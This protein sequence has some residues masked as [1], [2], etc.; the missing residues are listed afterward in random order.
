MNGIALIDCNS[1]YASC[2]QLFRPDLRDRAVVVLSNNDGCIIARNELAK[3][4]QIPMGVPFFQ[5]QRVLDQAGAAIFS[6]NYALYGDLSNRVMSLLEQTAPEIEVYSIDEAFADCSGL[7]LPKQIVLVQQMYQQVTQWVGLPIG[8]GLAPNKTLAKLANRLAKTDAHRP[9]MIGPGQAS[10]HEAQHRAQLLPQIPIHQVWGVGQRLAARLS[11]MG[12]KT[13]ADLAERDPTLIKRQFNRLLEGTLR[14]LRGER[15]FALNQ[16]PET[17]H[18][19]INSRSLK[20]STNDPTILKQAL[21][22]HAAKCGR[23]LRRQGLVARHLSIQLKGK[24]RGL[25][26]RRQTYQALDPVSN[27]SRQLI[28]HAHHLFEQLSQQDPTWQH[29]RFNK[30]GV[31]VGDL[32]T[33]DSVQLDLL[34]EQPSVRHQSLMTLMDRMNQKGLGQSFIAAEGGPQ[35]HWHMRRDRLSPR[36]TTVWQDLPRVS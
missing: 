4:L 32:Q 9:W 14:E 22:T 28:Q 36:Y 31:I 27:D 2:E 1:F 25:N 26:V 18:H 34:S 5:V 21:A 19:C 3:Q 15:I 6:S 10:L 13:A 24:V 33:A 8:I 7:D 20:W 35:Q 23:K 11:Q 30:V 29:I 12:I 16:G 17:Q